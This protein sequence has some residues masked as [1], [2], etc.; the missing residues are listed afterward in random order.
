MVWMQGGNKIQEQKRYTNK[1]KS[2]FLKTTP[3][4]KVVT[5][6]GEINL[7]NP[8]FWNWQ[9]CELV[10]CLE[11]YPKPWVFFSLKEKKRRFL[12]D[13][14]RKEEEDIQLDWYEERIGIMFSERQS[15]ETWKF[16]I[17]SAELQVGPRSIPLLKRKHR[18]SSAQ[19]LVPPPHGSYLW[20][21]RLCLGPTHCCPP[22]II[23]CSTM[24]W[25]MSW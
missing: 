21:S 6:V 16:P 19:H 7:G 11:F 4:N 9:R 5:F 3:R 15:D 22:L 10:K 24:L 2:W 20:F 1:R 13:T 8:L 12:L 18:L 23:L 17:H 25:E 14:K